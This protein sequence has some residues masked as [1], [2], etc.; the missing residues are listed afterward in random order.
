MKAHG[1]E[2]KCSSVTRIT[3]ERPSVGATHRLV[4]RRGASRRRSPGCP[5]RIERVG[6]G[7]GP[8]VILIH[9]LTGPRHHRAHRHTQNPQVKLVGQ[10]R[11]RQIR[12]LRIEQ[13]A[14]AGR[15]PCPGKHHPIQ[16]RARHRPGP[17]DRSPPL[18]PHRPGGAARPVRCIGSRPESRWP[19]RPEATSPDT[20]RSAR[21]PAPDEAHP[22]SFSAGNMA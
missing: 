20:R 22:G 15:R 7:R 6:N 14:G 17:R 1:E 13:Q 2:T 11:D 12:L 5:L 4:E 18:R 10:L 21:T 19:R 8:K 3:V 9:H 16:A